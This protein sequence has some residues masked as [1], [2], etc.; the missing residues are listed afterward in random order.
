MIEAVA[1]RVKQALYAPLC[2]AVLDTP[3][4][5]PA[6]DGLVIFSMIGTAVVIPY[7]VAV[8]SLHHRLGRGRVM[9]LDDGTLT[10]ADKALLAR[11]L[12]DPAIL[13]IRDVDVG[14]CP[15]GGCWE[16]LLTIQRLRADEYVIQLDSDT[17]TTAP[18]PEVVAAIEA[19]RSFTL[20]G[21]ETDLD[22]ILPVDQ[23]YARFYPGGEPGP[24]EA[25]G[26]IQ[27]A[28]ESILRDLAIPGLEQPRYVRGCAGFTGFARG[29]DPAL[30]AAFSHAAQEKLGSRWREWG[31]EQVTSNFVIANEPGALV[32][33]YRRYLNYWGEAVPQDACFVHYVGSYRFH[34]WR[35]IA[36]SRAA[37]RAMR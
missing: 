13:S 27:G 5:R 30:A 17:V 34:R 18:V 31:T 37:I 21:A 36:D 28:T 33:P 12:G 16:R 19:N 1:R 14:T 35:Y 4:V 24:E 6:D 29:G 10:P 15:T 9:I 7:L 25:T 2:R 22:E 23:F 8:K 3:P 20:L 26:H 11:Q 32:L